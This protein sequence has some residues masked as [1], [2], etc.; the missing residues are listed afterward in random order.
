MSS[1][2]K[3][4]DEPVILP[5]GGKPVSLRDAAEYIAALPE[6][7]HQRQAWKRATGSLM[8][9]ADGR[10]PMMSAYIALLRALS[11]SDAAQKLT[12]RKPA[13]H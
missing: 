6:W 2:S 7:E 12:R 8:S 5:E 13:R 10:L 11:Q 4:F 9:A 3:E 1:W